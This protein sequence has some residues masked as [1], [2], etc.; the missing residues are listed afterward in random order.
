M[1][2]SSSVV[3]AQ[4]YTYP[5]KS[6]GALSHIRIALDIR[7]P[8]WDRRWMVVDTAGVFI[9]QREFP[10]LALIQPQF[11]DGYLSLSAPGMD[12]IRLPLQRN[13]AP[14]RMVRVW[15][16][17]CEALDEGDDLAGWLSD[18]L[19]C[20]ARLVR[21]ADEYVRPVDPRYARYPAQTGFADAF[22]LLIVSEASLAELNRHL[23][24]RGNAPIPMSR[25]R[26]NLVVSGC[27]AYAEDT[28]RTVR[29]GSVTLDI[30][31]PCPRCVTTTVDQATGTIP[32]P[33]EP[34]AALNTFRKQDG[35]VMFAQNAIHRSVGVLAVGDLLVVERTSDA[36]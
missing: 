5:V 21:M 6:C 27:A 2:A 24:A 31:K 10:R 11:V 29:I 4:L 32:D 7:G 36:G 1:A 15:K 30:V 35:K 33:A 25:F 9:T 17:T 20:G 14:C 12:A 3:L 8:V 19:H 26:P 22:P 34:L 13:A 18:Y 28:W 23:V 16:D